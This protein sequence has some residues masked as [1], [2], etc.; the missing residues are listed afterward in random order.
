MSAVSAVSQRRRRRGWITT[1]VGVAILGFLLFPLYWMVNASFEPPKYLFDIPPQWFPIHGTLDGYRQ[2]LASQWR[3]VVTSLIIAFGTVAVTLVIAAPAAYALARFRF[4]ITVGVVFALLLVQM[5][6][7]IV[8]ANSLFDLY[9]NL[10]LLNSYPGLIIADCT[11][12]IPIAILIIR[13]FMLGIPRELSEAARVDGLGH[14][15][16]FLRIIVPVSKNALITAS[17]FA[18]L[19]GWSDFLLALTLTNQSTFIPL[20][21]SIYQYLGVNTAYWQQLMATA[22]IASLPAAVIL[23][24]GQRFISVGFTRSGLKG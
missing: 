11:G 3:S 18:F 2:A 20:S 12:S 19:A 10:G 23:V 17:I 14:W 4:K 6:P 21:I 9:N 24:I 8:L 5:I 13:A 1:A 7:G 16:T 22:V 15:G